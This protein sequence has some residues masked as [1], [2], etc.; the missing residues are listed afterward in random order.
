MPVTLGIDMG[1][2]GAR[3]AVTA[4]GALLATAAAD[5][6]VPPPARRRGEDLW[7]VLADCVRS[8]PADVS[9]DIAAIGIT[10]VRGAVIG[11]AGDGTPVTPLYPDF[12]AEAVAATRALADRVGELSFLAETGCP[13]FPLAGLPKMLL[14]SARPV[15]WWL[16]AQDYVTFRLTGEMAISAGSALRLGVL[17]ASTASVNRAVLANAGV[18]ADTIP[19]IVPVGQT[20]GFLTRDA[21]RDLALVAG[22]PVVAC[23][24]DVPAGFVATGAA[25][26]TA[27]VNL[28]TTT[29]VCRLATAAAAGKGFTHEVLGGGRRSFETGFGAGGITFDW[30]SRLFGMPHAALETEAE[31]A[32]PSGIIVE[33]ELLSPWGAQPAGMVGNISV[34]DGRGEVVRAAYRSVAARLI[35][36]LAELEAATGPIARLVL[37]GGGAASALLCR[38]IAHQWKGSLQRLPHR[39]LAAEGAASIA[40]EALAHARTVQRAAR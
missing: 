39:E 35:A 6:V 33:P 23:P 24:G 31:K 2:H 4:D 20:I 30:L 13:L 5:H 14:A 36:V 11:L 28:G 26:D 37:G 32:A 25:A 40:F 21:A 10:G 17:D 12:D 38:E 8:L 34:A 18:A 29:V 15:R 16:G 19:P 1:S 9:R 3:A 7:R 27:F 22:T